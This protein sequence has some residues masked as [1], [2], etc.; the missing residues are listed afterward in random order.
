[1]KGQIFLKLGLGFYMLLTLLGCDKD[2]KD[3]NHVR[4]LKN[5]SA[6]DVDIQVFFEGAAR[7][8][9]LI[10]SGDSAQTVAPCREEGDG[11]NVCRPSLDWSF[12]VFNPADSIF[13]KFDEKRTLSFCAVKFS[14]PDNGVQKSLLHL[15]NYEQ[16]LRDGHVFFT[17]TITNDDYEKAISIVE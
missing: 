11:Q 10:A 12:D 5:K 1:M 15:S 8:Q 17:Y 16:E 9:F 14:C 6:Y 3:Y 2:V 7:E 13:V 4:V